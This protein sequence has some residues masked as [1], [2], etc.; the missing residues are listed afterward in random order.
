LVLE[1]PE[2]E[3]QELLVVTVFSTHL[4]QLAAGLVETMVVALIMVAVVAVVEEPLEQAL[5]VVGPV[6]KAMRAGLELKAA[7]MAVEA[8]EVLAG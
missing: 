1:V 8:V 2:E 6:A 5:L 3:E 7:L 4:H